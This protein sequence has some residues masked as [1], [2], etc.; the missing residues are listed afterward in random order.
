MDD[1]GE[2]F[3]R[4]TLARLHSVKQLGE[5][6]L[7]Q[8]TDG[9]WGAVLGPSENSV[10]VLVQHL[11]GNMHAR[12]ATFP[13]GDGEGS[14]R[15]RDAEFDDAGLTPE[16]LLERW[17]A[18]WQLFFA[19]LERLPAR[20]LGLEV[21]VR[22]ERMTALAAVQRQLAH[23]SGHVYQIVLLAKHQRGREWRTLSIPRGESE[24]VNAE[25]WRRHGER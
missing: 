23:A 14:G 15:N 22:G 24:A 2:L 16:A 1:A 21:R 3:L 12:W 11:S 6:A 19:A 18:G 13:D 7:R 17:E 10:A 20:D 5:G 25:M 4:E 9:D 8:L